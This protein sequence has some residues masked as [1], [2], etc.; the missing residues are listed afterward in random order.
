[1]LYIFPYKAGSESAKA[2]AE[3]LNV[4]RIRRNNSKWRNKDGRIVL[5]WGAG[6][7][8]LPPHLQGE[9]IQWLNSPEAVS[10]AAH[11]AKAFKA[12]GEVGVSVVPFTEDY[13]EAQGW[14]EENACVVVRHTL[15]GKAGEGIELV[16]YDEVGG[17][18]KPELPEAPL[19]T[20]YVP[21]R[22]EFRIHVFRGEVFSEQYKARKKEVEQPNWKIRNHENGFV[23]AR[24]MDKEVPEVV[25]EEAI[26]AV[27]ALGL[28]FGAVDIGYNAKQEKAFV[29]EVNTACGLEGTT[30]EHYTEKFQALV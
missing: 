6:A 22:D 15:Q 30:L 5:N 9:D 21:K 1:M 20:K 19:Y 26:K 24:N 2:L 7:K 28:D 4:K 8:N 29:Y 3:A 16:S 14:L 25:K 13:R 23:F 18:P 10:K 12:M 17:E 27:N 11:K